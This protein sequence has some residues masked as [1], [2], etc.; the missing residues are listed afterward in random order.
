[1]AEQISPDSD[2]SALKEA[3]IGFLKSC[4]GAAGNMGVMRGLKL[5]PDKYWPIR[6]KLIDEGKIIRR[7]GRGGSV[8]LVEVAA[9]T[10][11]TPSSPPTE[12]SPQTVSRYQTEDALYDPIAKE[13]RENW[14]SE[15]RYRESIVEITARQGR[16]DTGG[17]W[18]RLD[19][20]VVGMTTYL[21][22]PGKHFDVTTFEIKKFDGL[23]VTAVYEA[24]A[25]RRAA[26]RSYAIFHVPELKESDPREGQIEVICEEAKKHGIGVI[27]VDNP[28]DYDTWEERVEPTR[29]APNPED[30]NDFIAVQLTE[31]T[32]SEV[33]E[34]FK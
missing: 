29:I 28:E 10:T 27:I 24:L 7:R 22:L 16:R 15:N 9:P 20:T 31:G 32:K 13:L 21:Y 18:S 1:M 25:H 26:T 30:L 33:V 11:A 19:I 3:I 5:S 6:N 4:G 8:S 23:V 34:W 2:P 14:T 12:P 17:A